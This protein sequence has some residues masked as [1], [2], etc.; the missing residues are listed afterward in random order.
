[1]SG[2]VEGAQ[3]GA[4]CND[5][6]DSCLRFVKPANRTREG[7]VEEIANGPLKSDESA[8]IMVAGQER[9]RDAITSG[10]DNLRC[11]AP[12]ALEVYLFPI[13]QAGLT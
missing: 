12:H 13:K 10:K 9:E 6:S 2:P 7:C 11:T 1:M 3:V 5:W 4:V 8:P